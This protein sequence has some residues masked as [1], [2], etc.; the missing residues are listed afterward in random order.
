MPE[1]LV[2][3]KAHENGALVQLPCVPGRLV[4][5]RL[6]LFEMDVPE[7][8]E[9]L[10]V[11]LIVIV[12][13][14][15]G[16]RQE[17]F[18]VT[19]CPTVELLVKKLVP[20]AQVPPWLL[21]TLTVP[22]VR[23]ASSVSARTTSNAVV[24]LLPVALLLNVSVYVIVPPAK[25]GPAGEIDFVTSVMAGSATET[26]M[27]VDGEPTVEPSIER[28]TLLLRVLATFAPV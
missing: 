24:A 17:M 20:P 28:E 26:G 5:V 16:S 15:P 7:G 4:Y 22:T 25:Y 27:F 1:P 9:A 3:T 18:T 12:I 14:L 21:E 2:P 8:V 13:E 19:T 23:L 10:M 11:A 6:A